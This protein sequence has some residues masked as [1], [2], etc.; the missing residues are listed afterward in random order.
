V[1]LISSAGVQLA[2]ILLIPNRTR[3][4]SPLIHPEAN[5]SG[6]YAMP[7]LTTP[8]SVDLYIA[9]LD[10]LADRYARVNN[11]NG[12]IDHWIVH[13]EVDYGWQWTNM[14]EQP[15]AVF[16]DHYTR[17]MRLADACMRSVNPH[18]RV[19][20]SL[21]HRWNVPDDQPW[22]T[23]APRS[24]LHHLIRTCQLEGDFPWGIAYHPYPENLWKSDTWNDKQVTDDQDTRLITLKNLP[25]L[26]A[27]VH[28]DLARQADG[29]IRPVILSEQGFHAPAE[30]EQALQRQCAALLYTWQQ[31]RKCPSILA[32][33]YHRPVD[34]PSE[35]GLRLGLRSLP[36]PDSPIGQPKPAWDVYKKIGTAEKGK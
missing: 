3:S 27:F 5:S 35:G 16:M 8:E 1:R 25:V 17:S 34:H 6:T 18:A 11:Q 26:D 4:D 30:D 15:F 7:N 23:Y 9:T 28:T 19:F 14:G 10:L 36:T 22:R 12:R 24:M 31:L 13:N 33:D 32:F 21:T 2:G 20:I 29:S